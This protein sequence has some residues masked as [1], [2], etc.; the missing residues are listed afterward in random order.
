[1][2]RR[3][4]KQSG[5]VRF[6]VP[7]A[8]PIS[9]RFNKVKPFKR[10]EAEPNPVKRVDLEKVSKA[11]KRAWRE[12]IH[13]NV[14]RIKSRQHARAFTM[15]KTRGRTALQIARTASMELK[16]IENYSSHDT[17]IAQSG[18]PIKAA[19][20]VAAGV[21]AA[22][23]A[24]I[25]GSAKRVGDAATDVG[26][27]ATDAIRQI[28]NAICGAFN[29]VREAAGSLWKLVVGAFA[30]WLLTKHANV[31][32]LLSIVLSLLGTHI[33]E[34]VDFFRSTFTLSDGAIRY[35]SFYDI[36]WNVVR[37]QSGSIDLL[38]TLV[39]MMCTLYVPAKSATVMTGEFLK[40]V[41]HF[42]RA[43]DGVKVFIETSLKL[44]EDFL[45][46][47]LRRSDDTRF[48]FGSKDKLFQA[49]CAKV[50]L[51]CKRFDEKPELAVKEIQEAHAL[52]LEGHGFYEVL[53]T[54]ASKKALDEHMQAIK[55]G[56]KPHMGALAAKNNVRAM[57][58]MF[59]IGGP[60]AIGK[61]TLT[62]ALGSMTLLLAGECSASECLANLWQKGT[63]EY[64]NGYVGQKCLV[65]DDCFQVKGVPGDM[66][67]EA[68]Q[69]IRA[70]G[71]WSYPLNYA[72]VES[73]GKFYLTTPLVIGTTNCKNVKDE[74]APFITQPEA[75][76]RRFQGSFWV[77][78][79]PSYRTEKGTLDYERLN[80][81]MMRRM[82]WLDHLDAVTVDDIINVV[83]WDAWVLHHHDFASSSVTGC[84]YTGGLAA[85]I[86][87]AASE[88]RRRRENNTTEVTNLEKI[89]NSLESKLVAEVEESR[90]VHNKRN[91]VS[92]CLEEFESASESDSVEIQAEA[93][94][95]KPFI[96]TFPLMDEAPEKANRSGLA[97]RVDEAVEEEKEFEEDVQKTR[98][99]LVAM[100]FDTMM[101]IGLRGFFENMFPE[102]FQNPLVGL[103][104]SYVGS[105]IVAMVRQVVTDLVCG[106]VGA[107]VSVVQSLLGMLG[108]GKTKVQAQSNEGVRVR[109]KVVQM[110]FPTIQPQVGVPPREDVHNHVYGNT[111]KCVL[112]APPNS[113]CGEFVIGQFLGIGSD[114]FLFPFHFIQDLEDALKEDK[115]AMLKFIHAKQNSNVV[116]VELSAFLAMPRFVVEGFDVAAVKMGI[117]GMKSVKNI[118]KYFLRQDEVTK[119]LRNSN[120][121]IRL[122]VARYQPKTQTLDRTVFHSPSCEYL[123]TVTLGHYG[124]RRGVV[125][126]KAST[127]L[128]DCGAPLTIAENRHYGGRC[129]FGFHIGGRDSAMIREGYSALLT[130]EV[131]H[132]L[133]DQLASYHDNV[134]SQSG[135]HIQQMTEREYEETVKV[136]G[137]SGVL[138]KTG[139]IGGSITF[140]GK[141]SHPIAM[142]GKTSLRK[143]IMHDHQ[144]F[145]PSPSRPAILHPIRKDGELISPMARGLAAYQSPQI[146]RRIPMM[147]AIVEMATRKHWDATMR[148]DRSIL[149]FE[150]AIC[151]PEHLKMKAINRK[152]SAG[153]KHRVSIPDPL[154]F[155]GKTWWL[156]FEGDVDF[157]TPQMQQ[158]KGDVDEIIKQ[159][160]SGVRCLH[161][162]TDFLKDELR[163][164]KKVD[165]VATRVIS[166]APFD[167]TVAVRMYFG[168]FLAAMFS[169][170]V[171]SG[172]APGINHYTEWFLLAEELLRRGDKLFDGDFSRF[173]SSEQPWIHEEIL[174]YIN[175]WYRV[176]D[177]W[178]SEHDK[179][180]SIL[181]MDLV[182]SRHV[183]GVGSTLDIV[184]QWNKSLPSG[185][186]LTTAV[187]SLYSLITLTTCY[188]S[189]TGD[190][191]DMWDK[192]YVCTFGDDNLSSVC[193]DV[194]DV[195]NQVTVAAHMK[196]IF[197]LTY[198]SGRKDGT[199]VPYSTI[200]EVTF[201]KRRFLRD[202]DEE[203]GFVTRVQNIGWVA[204]LAIDSF[205]Y[206]GYWFKDARDPRGD[207]ER[208]LE[209][210]L[211]ELALHPRAVWDKYFPTLE[212]WTMMNDVSLPFLSRE[213]ARAH[214]KSR[215]DVWF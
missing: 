198:T 48:Q 19:V 141:V 88:M 38:S 140:L 195:F 29:K 21:V 196:E 132:D 93:G 75:L 150:E 152:S 203:G 181:W 20:T 55:L 147:R 149:S 32:V 109:T 211:G 118:L 185:H 53:C 202:D 138:A 104:A 186:P 73:K 36:H 31:P 213:S 72:D 96:P 192:V 68:M 18:G 97:D 13:R 174:N 136:D 3:N 162:F 23:A 142:G 63:T 50:R 60:S 115:K 167:Y 37:A 86:K 79:S 105:R 177:N 24:K 164:N 54:P 33:P 51:V 74:W 212:E 82:K 1:M 49:W 194:A 191:K 207:L 35:R 158:L 17:I 15:S 87:E 25:A 83:P 44:F 47:V 7:S 94:T 179:I 56:L 80:A 85:A 22:S 106:I 42:P 124:D 161:L 70:I 122:D 170:Y 157:N 130:Y 143:S 125:R 173:D 172:M 201:L 67:S 101:T 131:V 58:Y 188:V 69:V 160:E 171:E 12:A 16:M 91:E 89:L 163:P 135:V 14:L 119:M 40:R 190:M 139:I 27:A 103:A 215:I 10:S 9:Q 45:N 210:M 117:S 81:E 133:Y 71:N 205:L 199:L 102:A 187:N 112:S 159:A 77:T 144:L 98:K 193:D 148:C 99:G 116:H 61:T 129:I 176:G 208:R 145:G 206:E 137:E 209:H 4:M 59:L 156:G 2:N 5:S 183:T 146:V 155:P 62:R 100:L 168:A 57:P 126:Y 180:R 95:S 113:E 182:H 114:V 184:V 90:P 76:V 127:V 84:E 121:N 214:I 128:G 6:G 154:K 197:D 92:E 123:R 11:D 34:I 64:W 108:L 165:D 169:S 65:M 120:T 110:D 8:L 134:E 43:V 52:M 26:G 39:A 111:Y 46:F 151:P 30:V 107:C 178:K 166:G 41:S 153:I 189:A 28:S 175:R 66:D 78:V 200:D 204:P